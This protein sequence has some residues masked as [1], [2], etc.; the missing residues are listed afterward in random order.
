MSKQPDPPVWAQVVIVAFGAL[1]GAIVLDLFFGKIPL[2]SDPMNLRLP[3]SRA[4]IAQEF[5]ALSIG[6]VIGGVFFSWAS[7]H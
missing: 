3:Y 2:F 5:G 4:E 1:F 6:A 7:R